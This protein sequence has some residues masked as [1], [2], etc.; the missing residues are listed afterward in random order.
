MIFYYVATVNVLPR[1]GPTGQDVDL[2]SVV[3]SSMPIVKQ[4]TPYLNHEDYKLDVLSSNI[5]GHVFA[6]IVQLKPT[7]SMIK[8]ETNDS[9]MH[10]FN[11]PG[12]DAM[13]S[14][15][16]VQL[17]MDRDALAKC[18]TPVP[19]AVKV[20][21]LLMSELIEGLRE[22]LKED[23]LHQTV[24]TNDG[25]CLHTVSYQGVAKMLLAQLASGDHP[26]YLAVAEKEAVY[27]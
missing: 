18:E 10:I 24:T 14:Q 26:P 22:G 12:V 1:T 4:F 20:V 2:H 13:A 8:D 9:V 23:I 19:Q 27:G 11:I 16:M 15:E 7:T 17:A 5:S 6:M 3:V 21:S 25:F